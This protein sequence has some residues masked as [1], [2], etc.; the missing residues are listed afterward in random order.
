MQQRNYSPKTKSWTLAEL[1]HYEPI[2]SL[3]TY[4]HSKTFI[5]STGINPLLTAASAVITIM[6]KL[7]KVGKYDNL[8]QLRHNL[9]YEIRAFESNSLAYDYPPQ[10]ITAA[11]FALCA[12]LDETI[13]HTI[14]GKAK[15]WHNDSLIAYFYRG[16][17]A[18]LSFLTII[19]KSLTNP[20][21]PTELLELF[22]ICLNLAYVGT[23]RIDASEFTRINRL[24]DIL[25]QTVKKRRRNKTTKPNVNANTVATPTH[26]DRSNPIPIW[27]VSIIVVLLL[28]SIY[29]GFNYL[30]ATSTQPVYAKLEHIIGNTHETY[31]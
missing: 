14:W 30:L 7:G 20:D 9:I 16:N 11:R 23:Y 22:Y 31:G 15:S 27:L 28:I 26:E 25:Y 2:S 10:I 19:E 3:K 24:S 13:V 29:T 1:T 12:A 18:D 4:H 17:S 21:T 8:S 5:A 6:T